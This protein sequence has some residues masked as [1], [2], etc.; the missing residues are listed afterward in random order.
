MAMN[1][2]LAQTVWVPTIQL[3]SSLIMLVNT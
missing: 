1:Q 2:S 3:C